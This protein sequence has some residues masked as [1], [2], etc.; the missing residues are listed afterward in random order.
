MTVV[1]CPACGATLSTRGPKPDGTVDCPRCGRSVTLPADA[2]A[3]TIASSPLPADDPG[4]T[5]TADGTAGTDGGT[6]AEGGT[7]QIPGYEVLEEV[8]RGGM[9]VVYKARQFNPP[10]I[11][12][13]KMILAGEHADPD[14][15]ARFSAEAEAIARLT[16]PSI[17]QIHQVGKWQPPAGGPA[18]PFLTLEFVAGQPLWRRLKSGPPVGER[19]AAALVQQLAR[20]VHYAHQQGIVHRDLKPANILLCGEEGPDTLGEV[21]IV[22]FGLAKPLDGFASTVT[23]GPRTRTGAVLGTPSYMAPEQATA[24]GAV[25]P[26][27]DVYALGA[28]LYELLTGRPPFEGESTLET[29]LQVANDDP[30]PPRRIRPNVPRDLETICLT[31]LAKD[32]ARR[33]PS[34]AALAKDLGRFLEGEPVKVRPPSRAERL[35]RWARR[36]KELLYLAGGAILALT[37][38]VAVALSRPG[39]QDDPRAEAPKNPPAPQAPTDDSPLLE[40]RRRMISSN[41]LR[42]I[43]F[44]L[45]NFHD[46]NGALPPAAIYDKNGRP[47]LSWRVAIL[48]YIEEDILYKEFK[49]DEPW[50]SPNNIKLIERMPKQYAVEGKS[51]GP[52]G[53]THYQAVVGTGLAWEP[54][55]PGAQS[56]RRGL[57]LTA[58]TDGTANTILVAEVADPVVWSKPDDATFDGKRQPRFGGV[59][60]DGFNVA[61]TDGSILFVRDTAKPEDLRAALTRNGGEIQSPTWYAPPTGPA[62]G[63]GVLSG[64]VTING[65]PARGARITLSQQDRNWVGGGGFGISVPINGEGRYSVT[66]PP[67]SY[68]VTIQTDPMVK[69]EMITPIPPK[70]GDPNT[71][72]LTMQVHS[73]EQ[74]ASYDLLGPGPQKVGE[75]VPKK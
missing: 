24:K 29:L 63:P 14:Q 40:Q 54:Q 62:T 19:A 10:R 23:D 49:L 69:G 31:C 70:Y 27:C 50:D 61:M 36:H 46:A 33:Y 45:H 52:P 21:K 74:T 34:A 28:I 11:V 43:G 66:L 72:G 67:G 30:E 12:A 20:A 55:P 2:T 15:L 41:N 25:G 9:G 37:V 35:G 64:R 32:P 48:P 4:P 7:P 17:A 75:A 47:L 42:Q 1:Q 60:K 58:F 8:G 57:T 16:H 18:V 22:D 13:L 53:T 68:R 44:A 73:G 59:V 71:S 65:Q 51:A 38:V 6:L 3:E 26:A 39:P 5:L 56:V